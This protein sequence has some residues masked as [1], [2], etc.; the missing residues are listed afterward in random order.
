MTDLAT[1]MQDYL[2]VRR[3][4]GHKLKG[5]ERLLGQFLDYYGQSG[6]SRLTIELAVAWATLP[7]DASPVWL[8]QRLSVVRG[9]A[10]W[11]Q[12]LEPDTEVPPKDILPANTR[13]AV[14][15]LY[16]DAEICSV[17]A[18]A[19]ALRAELCQ[20]TYAALVGLIA[21]TGARVGEMIGLD[22][23][24]VG[25]DSG[26]VRVRQSK[27]GK[28]RELLL[29]PSSVTALR[30]YATAR[31]RLCPAPKTE[32]FFVSLRRNRLIYETVWSTFSG[33][34]RAAGLSPR[35]ER[36]RPTIHG[37]RHSF[38]VHALL[39]WHAQRADVQALL[40]LLSTWMGHTDPASTYWY[41]S[42]APELLSLVARRLEQAFENEE[43]EEE[44][45]G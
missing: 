40:P 23:D 11:L 33:L 34:T 26:V 22:R 30:H 43:E 44:E 35:S 10:S 27:F 6:A 24:D 13:R 41:L 15:Y 1:A 2:A 20:E 12:T 7:E 17:M 18:A 31:D 36:C 21:V 8:A 14:P 3:A 16:S 32:A 19:R 28:S 25:L 42:A 4:L 38:A 39:H 9:F 45:E 29:H 37:L 5:A